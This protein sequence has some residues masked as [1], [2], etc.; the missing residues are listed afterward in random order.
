MFPA[1]SEKQQPEQKANEGLEPQLRHTHFLVAGLFKADR[2]EWAI[3][4][5]LPIGRT[6]DASQEKSDE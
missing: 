1:I 4:S 5:A 2:S 3:Q 6:L